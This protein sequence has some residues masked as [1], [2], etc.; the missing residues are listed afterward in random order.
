MILIE[1]IL[2]NVRKETAWAE[3]ANDMTVDMLILDQREAQKSR[4]RKHTQNGLDLGI[5][6]DR[7]VLLSDGDVIYTDDATNTMVV[8]QIDLRDVMVID[9]QRLQGSTPSEQIRISFELGHALGNQHW[10]AV[11]KENKVYVPLT[12]SEKVMESVM[13]THNFGNDTF[14]FVKGETILPILTNSESRL[15]FGGAEETDIHV[16]VAHHPRHDHNHDH[17]DGHSHDHN[18]DHGHGHDHDHDHKH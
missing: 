11:I 17:G 3:K 12:V 15:L 2:G 5:A 9:L 1:H 13:R 14:A 18:H 8:V 7:N 4:C 10:K 6:L 16:H